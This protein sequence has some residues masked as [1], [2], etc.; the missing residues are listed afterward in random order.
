MVTISEFFVYNVAMKS[1]E[2]SGDNNTF[3]INSQIAK[4]GVE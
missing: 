3:K 4:I 2:K 1:N